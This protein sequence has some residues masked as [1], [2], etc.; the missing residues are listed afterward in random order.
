MS[1]QEQKLYAAIEELADRPAPPSVIDAEAAI[2]S[3]RR[4]VKRRRGTRI[5]VV[6]T[7]G[8]IG[9][10]L[11][12]VVIPSHGGGGTIAAQPPAK[13]QALA[14]TAAGADPL[15]LSGTFGWLPPN[16]SNAGYSLHDSPTVVA[17]AR[18]GDVSPSTNTPTIW[19]TVY[20]K[21][22][23]PKLGTA[24]DGNAELRITAPDV[25]GH[26]AYWMTESAADPTNGGD[27]YL[28][29]QSSDG[30]WGEVHGYY[31]DT[32]DITG[33]LLRVAAGVDF[34]PHSVPL[35]LWISGLSKPI[36]TTEA[37]LDRP[38]LNGG[39][40]WDLFLSLEVNGADLQISVDPI[41]PNPPAPESAN[42]KTSNG[43]RACVV[44]GSPNAFKGGAAALLRDINLLGTD[45]EAWTTDVLR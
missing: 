14:A 18:G 22:T 23:T 43:L 19:L 35:P 32:S 42:C 6:A 39:G 45:P 31:L 26:P 16:A 13:T 20:P 10:A 12:A 27:A 15:T 8:V 40:A 36:V 37:D 33:E 34:A 1:I 2:S 11:A 44:V 24:A 5:A 17:V 21:G 4:I 3:G 29:W 7:L 9:F 30:Q 28:R 38:S 41:T 25:N